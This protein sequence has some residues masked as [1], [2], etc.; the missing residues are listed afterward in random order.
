MILKPFSATLNNTL[1]SDSGFLPLSENDTNRLL[2]ILPEEEEMLLTITDGLYLE[3]IKAENQCGTIVIERGIR[4]STPR[5][6]PRGT[7]VKFDTSLPVVEWLICNHDC[8]ADE[9]CPCTAVAN[10]GIIFPDARI[11]YPWQGSAVFNGSLPI[12]FGITGMPSWMQAEQGANFIR[13]HGTPRGAGD[14]D[15]G[16]AATNC[17]GKYAAVQIA[18]VKVDEV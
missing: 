8:C 6:F 16:I 17:S 1:T 5:R 18:T 10:A 15:V 9:E 2:S 11:G 14:F 3:W 7:C 13:F 12:T 4:G